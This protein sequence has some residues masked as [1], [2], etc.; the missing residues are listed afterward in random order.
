LLA[1][2]IGSTAAVAVLM[3]YFLNRTPE[4]NMSIAWQPNQEPPVKLSALRISFTAVASATLTLLLFAG[5][6]AAAP[7]IYNYYNPPPP[8]EFGIYDI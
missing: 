8:N 4:Q 5:V 3:R 1:G 7:K 2:F 6:F